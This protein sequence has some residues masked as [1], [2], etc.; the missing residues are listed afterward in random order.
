MFALAVVL[1]ALALL[2]LPGRHPA[3]RFGGGDVGLLRVEA[4][5]LAS[6]EP[7]RSPAW[8]AAHLDCR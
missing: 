2:V 1:H 4:V 6:C 8:S 3:L 5:R 7:A